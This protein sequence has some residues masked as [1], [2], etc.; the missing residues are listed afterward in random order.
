MKKPL[1]FFDLTIALA[2]PLSEAYA[3]GNAGWVPIVALNKEGTQAWQAHLDAC[4]AQAPIF[5]GR[6]GQAWVCGDVLLVQTSGEHE[7]GATHHQHKLHALS[8]EGQQLWVKAASAAPRPLLVGRQ[9]MILDQL[10]H[11][12]RPEPTPTADLHSEMLYRLLYLDP[13][14]GQLKK[15]SPVEWFTLSDLPKG[16]RKTSLLAQLQKHKSTQK[17]Q[18]EIKIF[19]HQS[20]PVSIEQEI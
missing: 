5:M 15:E 7:R 1:R 8:R 16:L 13:H 2:Q 20:A 17:I 14:T 18:V 11:H 9:L 19:A 3:L 12:S 10:Y 4:V 6:L